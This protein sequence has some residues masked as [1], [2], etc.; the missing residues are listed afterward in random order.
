MTNTFLYFKI[1]LRR[2]VH[3]DIKDF[4]LNNYFFYI[5]IYYNVIVFCIYESGCVKFDSF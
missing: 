5:I 4:H 1:V 2:K 3:K